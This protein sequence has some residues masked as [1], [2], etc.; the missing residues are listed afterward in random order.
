MSGDPP[1]LT[2]FSHLAVMVVEVA[3]ANVGSDGDAGS[4]DSDGSELNSGVEAASGL[5]TVSE[6]DQTAWPV[7]ERAW[8]V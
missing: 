4:C 2:G 5:S 7:R 3:L 6:A 8:H 1:I